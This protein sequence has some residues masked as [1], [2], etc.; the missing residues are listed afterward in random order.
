ML[1]DK[2]IERIEN[3][4][5]CIENIPNEIGNAKKE[6]SNRARNV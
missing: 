5:N 2:I 1:I 6:N 4:K 3:E